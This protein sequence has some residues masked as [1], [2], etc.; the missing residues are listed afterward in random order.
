MIFDLV[1]K[2]NLL[3]ILRFVISPTWILSFG[4]LEILTIKEIGERLQSGS[5]YSDKVNVWTESKII[6]FF[7]MGILILKYIIRNNAN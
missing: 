4:M 5:Q 1:S 6:N 2:L 3:R 7:L